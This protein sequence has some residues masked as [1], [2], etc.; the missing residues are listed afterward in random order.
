MK[1]ERILRQKL[2]LIL[3]LSISLFSCFKLNAQT[4]IDYK[5]KKLF[6]G[7][8]ID[9]CQT[10]IEKE[11]VTNTIYKFKGEEFDTI[12]ANKYKLHLKKITFAPSFKLRNNKQSLVDCD[13]TLIVLQPV[14]FYQST[15]H[16]KVDYEKFYGHSVS[17]IMHFSDS[18]KAND[19]YKNLCDSIATNLGKEAF[20]GELT[21]DDIVVG[22]STIIN[23]DMKNNGYE[24]KRDLEIS[25][26]KY[27]KL[28]V[29]NIYFSK[30]TIT[31]ENCDNQ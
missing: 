7:L 14:F 18:I 25:I 24:Y 9:S 5:L 15:S 21:V 10:K 12:G 1:K 2:I 19:S 22:N 23:I 3:T 4:D 11:I 16:G 28:Y 27:E 13:S 6:F 17:I 30:Y 31:T 26:R 8:N 20:S 29:V